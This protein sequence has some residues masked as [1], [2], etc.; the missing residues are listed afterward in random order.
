MKALVF[1]REIVGFADFIPFLAK[2]VSD[3]IPFLET[4]NQKLAYKSIIA[5]FCAQK[6]DENG[7]KRYNVKK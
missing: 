2:R 4:N 1:Y 6:V 3:F 7:Q 5:C